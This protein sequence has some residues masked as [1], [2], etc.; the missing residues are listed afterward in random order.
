MVR[1]AGCAGVVVALTMW[2]TAVAD[3]APGQGKAKGARKQERGDG[4]G[5]PAEV[6]K[7]FDKDGDG[8]L[9]DAERAAAKKAREERGGR[10]GRPG[11]PGGGGGSGD[12]KLR[13]EILKRFDKDGDGKLN[14][15]ERAAAKKAHD[16][17]KN[18]KK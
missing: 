10:P 14:D 5:I 4:Q 13:E 8:K 12:G 2:L 18:T 6:L 1:S 11:Q 7:R 17:R 16:E 3:A 15:E 9:N